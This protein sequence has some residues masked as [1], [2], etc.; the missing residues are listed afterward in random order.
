MK[1]ETKK[2]IDKIL[3]YVITSLLFIIG[4]IA[5]TVSAII[6]SHKYANQILDVPTFTEQNNTTEDIHHNTD[7]FING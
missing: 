1:Y 7:H 4:L 6:A 5:M 2:K 3:Y